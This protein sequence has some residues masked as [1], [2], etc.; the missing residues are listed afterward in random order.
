MSLVETGPSRSRNSLAAPLQSSGVDVYSSLV[1]CHLSR[2]AAIT[3]NANLSRLSAQ[4]AVDLLAAS[5]PEAPVIDPSTLVRLLISIFKQIGIRVDLFASLDAASPDDVAV[6][7]VQRAPEG[8]Y[9]MGE[10][11]RERA[12]G[13]LVQVL[14]AASE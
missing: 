1:V 2:T 12:I 8:V 13:V 9:P 7:P 10:V 5:D 4:A 3:S 14:D 6:E 11:A